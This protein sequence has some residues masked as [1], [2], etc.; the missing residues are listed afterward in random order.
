IRE[1]AV[2]SVN[3][4]NSD[5]DRA[6]LDQE[7]QQRLQEIDRI[8]SQTSFNGRNV[9]DGS[10]GSALFQV[11][12]NVGET[13]GL[14]QN[15][16]V[17]T[18]DVGATATATSV[19]LSTLI[20]PATS[21]AVPATSGALGLFVGDNEAVG[22]GSSDFVL[23]L[24][25]GANSLVAT[26]TVADGGPLA[27]AG[28]AGAIN[29][30]FDGTAS[31][32]ATKNGFT[33]DFGGALDLETA[34]T[35]GTLAFS[36]ADGANFD[37]TQSVAGDR[38]D[39]FVGFASIPLVQAGYPFNGPTADSESITT[40]DG[41]EAVT[42]S[43]LTVN[44]DLNIQFGDSNAIAVENGVYSTVQSF[45]DA[46]N[47]ALGSNGT[48]FLDGDTNVLSITSGEAITISG[49]QAATVFTA[50]EFAALGSLDDVNV[51]TVAG[52]NAAI[53][54]ID[55]ALTSASDLRSTFGA[56]QNRF[57]STI[58]NLSGTA[59]NLSASRSRIQDAD[60]AAETAALT[61]AQILQQAGISVLSQAN[62]QPQN[63]LALLN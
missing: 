59:E 40:S 41:S 63:V 18:A 1:L 51:L 48:A 3:A 28:V 47:M 17:R 26:V 44:N 13:I 42:A 19:D 62:A 52:A 8:G 7:V 57:E 14:N 39:D 9:L 35:S 29:T 43:T 61:R 20:S 22:L 38:F 16:S 33:I 2:Q 6:T 27:A 24:D 25:D 11:G 4:T 12:A 32:G 21:D 5:T 60:F 49:A 15:T 37:V 45:V 34:I 10:F 50:T 53:Q 31:D 56:I 58:A 23:T 55:A 54:R 46:I 36:R 30:A